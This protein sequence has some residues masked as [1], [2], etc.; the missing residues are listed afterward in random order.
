MFWASAPSQI[1]I[2]IWACAQDVAQSSG[3][4]CTI[5]LLS[6]IHVTEL[7]K[8][9]AS[10]YPHHLETLIW[11]YVILWLLTF[12]SLKTGFHIIYHVSLTAESQTHK[13]KLIMLVW[14]KHKCLF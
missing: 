5:L 3:K 2:T 13:N 12:H 14:K 9:A 10:N 7:R 4:I 11:L 1:F 8:Q 6:R